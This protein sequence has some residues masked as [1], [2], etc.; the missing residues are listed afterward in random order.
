M[1]LK[2][3]A[4]LIAVFVLS[5]ACFVP[6]S[7]PMKH[8]GLND[9]DKT[10]LSQLDVDLQRIANHGWSI[11]KRLPCQPE[12]SPLNNCASYAN[13][14]TSEVVMVGASPLTN[15]H[16]VYAHELAHVEEFEEM[17]NDERILFF[18]A[19][20]TELNWCD[21][22]ACDDF[23]FWYNPSVEAYERPFEIFTDAL[24]FNYV[25]SDYTPIYGT[26]IW[27]NARGTDVDPQLAALA[28]QLVNN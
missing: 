17:T 4:M 20:K 24:A 26:A 27:G 22:F 6:L 8:T 14:E 12:L 10:T 15:R 28:L 16:S 7:Y 13:N 3:I 25:P 2:T 21:R 11:E 19:M 1:K 23:N 9:T 5:T 18:E